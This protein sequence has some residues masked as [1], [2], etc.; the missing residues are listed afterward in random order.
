MRRFGPSFAGH[1]QS[2]PCV[3]SQN[4]I[5]IRVVQT[6][7]LIRLRLKVLVESD[8]IFGAVHSLSLRIQDVL[9]RLALLAYR[10]F[11]D[12]QI[13]TQVLRLDVIDVR[14]TL[15]RVRPVVKRAGCRKTRCYT[16]M[17]QKV[18]FAILHKRN[19]HT[20]V[21][22][23]LRRG[24]EGQVAC[25]AQIHRVSRLIRRTGTIRFGVPAFE[26]ILRQQTM[27]PEHY[28][29]LTQHGIS[30]FNRIAEMAVV[31]ILHPFARI[32]RN[33]LQ[34]SVVFVFIYV[35]AA[36]TVLTDNLFTSDDGNGISFLLHA[37]TG[38]T[39]SRIGSTEFRV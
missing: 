10:V 18:P 12:K 25:F 37:P 9:V 5:W 8:G 36:P 33:E 27:F 19:S 14:H 31:L 24:I 30:R 16:R 22:F 7:I 34:T 32:R 13:R 38:N 23:V 2:R 6:D 1:E 26:I 28:L 15:P 21:S 39:L 17:R 20:D 29:R 3:I 35:D 4:G 11:T